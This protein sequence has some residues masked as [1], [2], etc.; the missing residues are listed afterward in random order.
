MTELDALRRVFA[1]VPEP[2]EASVL[3]AR[4]RLLAAIE[5]AVGVRP[6]G[7]RRWL[8]LTAAVAVGVAAT[9]AGVFAFAIP[10]GDTLT[11][12]EIA[13]AAAR[14]LTPSRGA[15]LHSVVR[16]S[17]DPAGVNGW[18]PSTTERWVATGKPQ[19][20]HERDQEFE[21]ETGPCGSIRYYRLLNLLSVDLSLYP[22]YV[23]QLA[24]PAEEYLRAY[25]GGN[26]TYRGKTTFRGIPAYTL[27]LSFPSYPLV[28]TYTVRRDNYYP[29]R[30][31]RRHGSYAGVYTYSAFDRIARM[32]STEKLLHMAPRGNA[33]LVG[34]GFRRPR[35][36]CQ[37][38]ASYER[39]TRGDEKP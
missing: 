5:P 29:L 28:V 37:G 12:P 13:A 35:P 27:A 31:I 36:G 8:R 22:D 2:D 16:Q 30:T 39:L 19:T 10:H 20:V 7:Q 34:P 24:D 21:W 11:G 6:L 33:F 23:H 17:F 15:I 26:V 1:A 18:R 38:F 25:R 9:L 32:A 3:A 4:A 14:A